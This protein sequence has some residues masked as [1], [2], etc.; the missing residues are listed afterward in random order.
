MSGVLE[1]LMQEVAAL[2]EEVALLR[3]ARGTALL[4][5][6][7]AADLLSMTPEAVETLSKRHK[8]PR[9]ALPNGRIR[10]ERDALLRWAKGE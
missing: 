9:V 5:K 6:H 7:G 3:N 10:F 8:L 2:R 1:E 4:D